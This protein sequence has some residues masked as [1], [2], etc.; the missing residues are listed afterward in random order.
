M[1]YNLVSFIGI[2]KIRF[3]FWWFWVVFIEVFIYGGIFDVYISYDFL[4][5]FF[6]ICYGIL[7][8]KNLEMLVELD[9]LCRK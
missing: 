4:F 7:K 1:V 8:C 6:F 3:C 9:C 5:D 2:S